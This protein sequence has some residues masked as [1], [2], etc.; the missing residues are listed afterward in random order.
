MLRVRMQRA[1][2]ARLSASMSVSLTLLALA[3]GCG[4]SGNAKAGPDAKGPEVTSV[5]PSDPY[6]A[7]PVDAIV[8][9]TFSKSIDPSA[10]NK[11]TFTLV[12]AG[13]LTTVSARVTYDAS[14]RRATLD[15][16]DPLEPT[17]VY[18]A[19][20]TTGVTDT[21]GNPMA[22]AR[23]WLVVT[24]GGALPGG[25]LIKREA[26]ANAVN[27][28]ATGALTIARPTGTV[29]GD[30]LVACLALNTRRVVP[31]G[32]PADWVPIASETSIP[33]PHVFGYYKVAGASEPADYTWAL[34]SP[35]QNSGGIARYSGVNT[36]KPI[37]A[38]V[39]SASKVAAVAGTIPGVVTTTSRTMLVGCM[40]ANSSTA[41]VTFASPAGM[42]DV[43]DLG[44]K[45]HELAEGLQAAAGASGDKTWAFHARREWAGWLAALRP[46]LTDDRT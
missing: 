17:A 19:R 11:D 3:A 35:A 20:L 1:H 16:T 30:V 8:Q 45:R 4:G 40:A 5:S 42:V 26:T 2:V 34:S 9:A 27:T 15:P 36:T 37:D 28:T 32:T 46:T 31:G 22:A 12:R 29:P 43:W 25:A 23:D 13:S 44:G 41:A 24:G 18:S 7:I 21:A 6:T 38:V 10:V 33:N 14:T 39:T